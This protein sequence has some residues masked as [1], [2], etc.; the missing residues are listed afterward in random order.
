MADELTTKRI[1]NLPA[2][3]APAAGDV[4]VV[5]NETTGTKKL[6]VTSLIDTTPTEGS[7][8]A[9]SSG[10]V[11]EALQY[12]GLPED[13]KV[14]LLACFEHVAWIDE[15]GQDYYDALYDALYPTTGLVSIYAVFTQG[16]AVIYPTTPLNDL[17]AYLVVTGH[18]NDGT[19]KTITDYALSG[20]LEVGTSTV[21]VSKE[22]KTTTFDVV[23]TQPYWDYEWYASSKTIPEGMTAVAYDFTTEEGALFVTEPNI[24]FDYI[25]S[26]RIQVEMV[27]FIIKHDAIEFTGSNPQIQIIN[28]VSGDNKQGVK[29]IWNFDGAGTSGVGAIG[30]NGV[31][32]ILNIDT[33]TYHLIDITNNNNVYTLEV[34]GSP[35]A[36]QQNTNQTQYLDHTGIITASRVD[37]NYYHAYIKT[38]KFKKL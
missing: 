5:D 17:K 30:I 15:H 33:T 3:S 25:G 16:G 24:D 19:S 28:S 29:F 2:E 38:I 14:A 13:A 23:V 4:F 9:I 18:Y 8:K 22:G 37:G 10:G 34:D 7:A 32:T 26:C 20:T 36:L 27:G 21:T 12:A 11:Y 31:N 6:P 1:I 35:I